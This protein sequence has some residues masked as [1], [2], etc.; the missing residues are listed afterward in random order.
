[1]ANALGGKFISAIQQAISRRIGGVRRD[2]E[3]QIRELRALVSRLEV[4]ITA[5]QA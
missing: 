2:L 1:M 3:A 5:G 4:L